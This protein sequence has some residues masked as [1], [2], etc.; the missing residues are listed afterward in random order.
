MSQFAFLASEFPEIHGLAIRAEVMAR[1]DARIACGYARLTLEAMVGWLYDHDGSL[2]PPYERTLSARI[3]E[4]SF[5][6]LVGVAL[7][8]KARV[9][10]D[11]GNKAVH[12]ARAVPAADGVAA[13]REL[14]HLTYWLARTY[15]RG[16][17]PT[18]TLTFSAEALPLTTTVAIDRLD[19]LKE[20][21]RRYVE[22]VEAREAEE[23]RRRASEEERERLEAQ[24]TVARAEIAAV[25]AA[26]ART[27]DT[28]DYGEAET[29]HRFIDLLLQ[30]AGWPCDRPGLDTEYP[31]TGMPN[32]S[33]EGYVDY[34]LWA[35]DG[36]PLGLLE[37]KRT[38]KEPRAGQQQAKLYAD[39]LEARF[40][41]RPVIFY[42]NGYEHWIWDDARYAPRP[43]Q[44]FLTRD[45]LEL[46]VLRR[47]TLKPLGAAAIDPN[48]VERYYQSRA[49]R[50]VTQAFE[51]D[52]QRKALLVMA[53]GS[54]KTRTVIA[55]CDLL[56]KAN[57]V[58]RVLFLADRTALVNQ[59]V[60]AFKAHLPSASPVNLV[61]DKETVGRVYVSTY[62]TMMNLIDQGGEGPRRF[63]PG[64]FDLIVIDEAHRSVYR[65]FGAIFD[66][67][68]ALLVGL[69]ATPKAE[70]D[71]DTY[72]LFDLQ[73]GVPTD[74]YDLDEAVKDG[75]LV[76]MQAVSVPLKFP[77]EGIRYDDLSEEEKEAWDAV[78]WDEDGNVPAAVEPAALNKWLF[79][80]D[81]VDKVLEH[82]MREGQKVADGDRLGKTI[83]FAKSQAHARFIVERFDVAYPHLKGSFARV[84]TSGESYAQSLLDDFS[85][86]GKAPHIAVSV[87]M[88]DTGV[89][90]PEIVN[91]VFFKIVRS[92]TKFW[93]MLGRGTRLR[94]DLF[95][96]G[97]HKTHFSVFDFCQ[98]F[99]FFNQNP[100]IAEPAGGESLG[101]R[102]FAARVGLIAALDEAAAAPAGTYPPPAP[103]MVAVAAE[104]G[105]PVHTLTAEELRASLAER[106][107][108][109]VAQMSL[110]NF[111]VRPKRRLV[112]TWA[113]AESW[114]A[115][116]LD[117]QHD[118][119]DGLAGLPSGLT[120]DD[121][122]AKEFDLLILRAQLAALR[123][124]PALATEKDKVV[125][126][127]GLLEE[128]SNI[129]QVAR[130]MILIQEIQTEDFWTG[131]TAPILETVRRRLRLLIG[132]IEPKRRPIIYTDFEDEIGEAR[133]VSLP[134]G[135]A[136]TDMAR[137][138][139][140]A[141]E[142]LKDNESHIAVLKL[143]RNEPLT[144]TDLAELERIFLEAGVAGSDDLERVR[145]EGGLGRFVRSLVGLDREAA[146]AAFSEFTAGHALTAQQ[147][148]F[149]NLVIDHLTE[150]GEMEPRLLYESPFTDFD[151]LGVAGVFP[152]GE[153]EE[154]IGI[155]EE[156]K[157]RAA[158]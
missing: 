9:V 140:K 75:F 53:T 94:P 121:I 153:A 43:I 23:A 26:N 118:L 4:P 100:D 70:I 84:I 113:R 13:V 65:K 95:G 152:G 145:A 108:Q 80:A 33:G 37:A 115:L 87:D 154:V 132:L 71:R 3:H 29:R 128:L 34:V 72:R 68:D 83:I 78:E 69:T 93:Q 10:K 55:L 148:E 135:A 129:P 1:A 25:K 92:K 58:R 30:E 114:A 105:P 137:F 85:Q 124:D 125:K 79:N 82:L 127:A 111:L 32:A 88:L 24:L 63:G 47:S 17:K 130:E 61:T 146:K 73:R 45:E 57:W 156:V 12:E 99:E 67:F 31:V 44:G 151:P 150:R 107:R 116:T 8:A 41:Q 50:H 39:A 136:G 64:H 59:A 139:L 141:R 155:L 18:G 56:M 117:A 15:A 122:A 133:D 2:R 97:R 90:V 22:A 119:V 38:T 142:F 76:P 102:L 42:S 110:D 5:Q 81:T 11:L 49:I 40:S 96:P 35:A 74:A 48:I 112:E 144:P 60:A 91:L 106:L 157:R 27:P 143:R 36:K 126:I 77:R 6:R 101:K 21:A 103:A 7:T 66:Y 16:E 134:G 109:E 62:P 54:G 28:H 120:D 158:A 149:V 138:R 98:N 20:A 104:G 89:D 86:E 46:A 147:I 123:N 131:V 51:T 19:Q 52:R 14:F